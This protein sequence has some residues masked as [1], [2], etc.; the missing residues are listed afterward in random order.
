MPAFVVPYA[1]AIIDV[2]EG[3]QMISN[4]VDCDSEH[5][6]LGMRVAVEFHPI[7]GG[8]VLPY[9]CPTETG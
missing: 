9:F 3:Y 8:M 6:H 4:I 7:G 1:P 2:D 5:I